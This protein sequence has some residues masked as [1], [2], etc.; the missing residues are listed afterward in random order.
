M[1][2]PIFATVLRVQRGRCPPFWPDILQGYRGGAVGRSQVLRNESSRKCLD[3]IHKRR[4]A[5]PGEGGLEK[6][7]KSGHILLFSM[8]FYCLNW[9]HGGNPRRPLWM[10][11][12]FKMYGTKQTLKVGQKRSV[13]RKK[14]VHRKKQYLLCTWHREFWPMKKYSP[15]PNLYLEKPSSREFS[16]LQ[17][18]FV[19][20]TGVFFNTKKFSNVGV[21][22]V[23]D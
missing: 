20:N 3:A 19:G 22:G 21:D 2:E 8:K 4:P 17:E 23:I 7:K 18:Y 15:S 9:T 5:H 13:K 11:P 12:Y 1:L 6:P 10:A 14:W 16:N